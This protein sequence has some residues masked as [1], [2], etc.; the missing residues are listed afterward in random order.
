MARNV[1]KTELSDATKINQKANERRL[2]ER[3]TN[4]LYKE[5]NALVAR[6]NKTGTLGVKQSERLNEIIGQILENEKKLNPE[7]E[8][9]VKIGKDLL[10]TKPSKG[11]SYWIHRSKDIGSMKKQF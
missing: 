5:R 9:G 6:L 7:R 1:N 11:S 2:V 3:E 4:S 8:K 10:K